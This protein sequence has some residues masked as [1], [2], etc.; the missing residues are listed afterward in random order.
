MK[1]RHSL[2]LAAAVLPLL[3]TACQSATDSPR[4][5]NIIN[6]V[7]YTEPRKE[8]VTE[9]VLYTATRLEAEDLR[10]KDL[11]A[12]WL[13]E[14]D[15]LI[16]SSYQHLMKEEL[17]RGC[18][19]GAWWEITQPQVEAAG[20][21]WRG[22]YP[23]DWHANVGFSVGYTPEERV[24]LVDVYMEK[25]RQ[26]FG[27]YPKSV[28]SWMIDAGTLAYLYDRY[29]IEASCNCR[30]QV[31]TDGYTLWGGYWN[32]AYYPSRE[33]AYM[34]A[35]TAEGAIGVPVFRM[36]G[37]D[38]IY[39]Y[40]AGVGGAVQGVV[41]LEPVY[42]KAGGDPVW[43][44]WFFRMF[45]EE[46]HMGYNYGQAGQEN[47]FTWRKIGKG[48]LYQTE[49]IAALRAAGKIR[50]ET[51]GE[52]G[53]WFKETYA[54]TPPTS[55]ITTEDYQGNQRKVLWFNSRNYR[56]HL[57]WEG[58]SL[59]LRDIHVFDEKLRSPYLDA[60]ETTP[61]F[62]YETLPFVDGCLWST[63][64]RMAGLYFVTPGFEGGDPVFS[65]R[66]GGRRQEVVW[67]SAAGQGRFVLS[68]P[69]DDLRVYAEGVPEGWYL[70]LK[71][72][73]GTQLPFTEI[74]SERLSARYLDTD[75]CLTLQEG[76]FED[77]RA[78]GD[79]QVLRIRPAAGR[80]TMCF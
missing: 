51:L 5:V 58:P 32:G 23:W 21:E 56:A 43:V 49:Q 25:F 64:E 35:Q 68:F 40:D 47:S 54:V 3:L 62:H 14:Y 59:R 13:L 33:N 77:C 20:L 28:G 39:Q 34:P 50:V 16:D 76:G 74:S 22:R 2:M 29:G 73:S 57:L 48:L 17:Q 65:V 78:E 15:A 37:S 66:D 44:D 6:F 7:R 38:P 72:N 30:D 53:R 70:D 75:Y 45:T 46:P 26:I 41:T 55:V 4:I 12:T 60:P 9:E 10:S 71:V 18:E 11:V 61:V 24:K 79:G 31:G 67:P 80:I 36:L 1:N 27:F 19:V 52:T 63:A 69:E 8:V 42:P